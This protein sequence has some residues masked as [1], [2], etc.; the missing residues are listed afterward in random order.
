MRR[1]TRMTVLVAPICTQCEY[2]DVSQRMLSYTAG[3]SGVHAPHPA[4]FQRARSPV[5][6]TWK[7]SAIRE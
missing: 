6:P 4:E 7:A 3:G 2:V 5:G 1:S